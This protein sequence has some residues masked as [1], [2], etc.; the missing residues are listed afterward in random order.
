MEAAW[1][2]QKL[3]AEVTDK[4]MLVRSSRAVLILA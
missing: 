4:K 1:V 3:E 2:T